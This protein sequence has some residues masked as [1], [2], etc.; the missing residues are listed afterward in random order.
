MALS[1]TTI[2]VLVSLTYNDI[3]FIVHTTDSAQDFYALF[4]QVEESDRVTPTEAWSEIGPE[5]RVPVDSNDDSEFD[6]QDILQKEFTTHIDNPDTGTFTKLDGYVRKY[7]IKYYERYGTAQ[8]KLNEGTSSAFYAVQGGIGHL[9]EKQ[10]EGVSTDWWS[11]L[12]AQKFFLSDM[13]Q[14][15]I[16][17]QIIGEEYREKLFWYN[18]SVV[19]NPSL[20]AKVYYTDKEPVNVSIQQISADQHEIYELEA[21][22]IKI[23]ITD[24]AAYA[25][26]IFVSS[27]SDLSI[28]Q[29]YIIERAYYRRIKYFI[30]NNKYHLTENRIFTGE[31]KEQGKYTKEI[32]LSLES[33]ESKENDISE[34]I[35]R[36]AS[37]GL[38][39]KE[40]LMHLREFYTAEKKYEFLY[41][42]QYESYLLVP[43]V[44]DSN[45][46]KLPESEETIFSHKLKYRFGY[47]SQFSDNLL[48]I[49]PILTAPTPDEYNLPLDE[50]TGVIQYTTAILVV[51]GICYPGPGFIQLQKVS[52]SSIAFSLEARFALFIR[53]VS[54]DETEVKFII[55]NTEISTEYKV[56][57]DSNAIL[58]KNNLNY[59][60][61][62]GDWEFTMGTESLNSDFTAWTDGTDPL[63][64]TLNITRPIVT[65]DLRTQQVLVRL[66]SDIKER[67]LIYNLDTWENISID[68][69]VDDLYD[70]HSAEITVTDYAYGVEISSDNQTIKLFVGIVVPD[71][72]IG[73]SG[74]YNHVDFGIIDYNPTNDKILLVYREGTAHTSGPS[75]LLSKLSTNGGVTFGAPITVVPVSGSFNYVNHAGGYTPT[76]RFVLIYDRSDV[77]LNLYTRYSDDDGIS[78]S[79]ETL[80]TGLDSVGF[81]GH[82][83]GI[84][85]NVLELED[86]KIG[87][88]ILTFGVTERKFGIIISSNNGATFTVVRYAPAVTIGVVEPAQS[89]AE[90][91]MVK[92]SNG[93]ILCVLRDGRTSGGT[94]YMYQYI[95]D[96]YG[97]TWTFQGMTDFDSSTPSGA[98]Y[99]MLPKL[100]IAT[101][102]GQ[103][104]IVLTYTN[105][106]D[107]KVK[108]IVGLP[109]EIIKVDGNLRWDDDTLVEFH[110]WASPYTADG[111]G[112]ALYP[113]GKFI[114]IYCAGD[115]SS[116]SAALLNLFTTPNDENEVASELGIS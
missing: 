33:E 101:V 62:L 39:K 45:K 47:S 105:R 22:Y 38:V 66:F 94:N 79:A 5:L 36:E 112:T 103:I 83:S 108:R 2:P 109:S 69:T 26:E 31:D 106:T 98:S 111:N 81:T 110:T 67:T 64:I 12:Q 28:R 18:W 115:Q 60:N 59:R 100:Y 82:T 3:I 24:P 96:D 61:E 52:D 53:D 40:W 16:T 50:A 86:G 8:I 25:Y 34:E 87:I 20:V 44:F 97:V 77:P 46:L 6:I 89:Y 76:G 72:I 102:H 37:T 73:T 68:N 29:L 116:G 17:N 9:T 92:F 91:T 11:Q 78:W 55:S 57:I 15:K 84:T 41:S 56:L 104:V 114:G 54:K 93:N 51:K 23:G 95:S 107:H 10:Y 32:V 74:L 70:Y 1:L 43:I 85:N 71:L 113:N 63:N 65:N 7:R 49:S 99:V 80:V 90:P 4:I 14:G 48:F 58:N 75:T 21:S 30:Y 42:V 19:S 88:P 13:P 27:A 35:P